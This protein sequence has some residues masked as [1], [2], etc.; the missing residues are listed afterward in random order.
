MSKSEKEKHHQRISNS[1]STT[2]LYTISIHNTTPF[3]IP[4]QTWVPLDLPLVRA[5]GMVDIVQ[6]IRV[7]SA[8]VA[9]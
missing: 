6:E 4:R 8:S 2:R 5:E 3:S 1:K 7:M 9:V